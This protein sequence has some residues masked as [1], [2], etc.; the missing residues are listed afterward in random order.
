MFVVDLR[1][2]RRQRGRGRLP[3]SI[4][5]HGGP[6]S[7][8]GPHRFRTPT[9]TDTPIANRGGNRRRHAGL[10]QL[11][12]ADRGRRRWRRCHGTGDQSTAVRVLQVLLLVVVMTVVVLLLKRG[13]SPV[14]SATISTT[15]SVA[16]RCKL[17]ID[18]GRRGHRRR[19]VVTGYLRRLV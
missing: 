13:R 14:V 1:H 11:P 2:P 18:A 19:P 10:A 15:A 9:T 6:I 12:I 8:N 17:G 16:T 4:P 5:A 7:R 3:L